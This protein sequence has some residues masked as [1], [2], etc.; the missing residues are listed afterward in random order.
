MS[1][2]IYVCCVFLSDLAQRQKYKVLQQRIPNCIKVEC[3]MLNVRD[4]KQRNNKEA[5]MK[6]NQQ[7]LRQI[8]KTKMFSP[9]FSKLKD[10]KILYL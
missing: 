2:R 9:V 7:I 3:N 5:S 8:N 1:L 4:K 6:V 10:V